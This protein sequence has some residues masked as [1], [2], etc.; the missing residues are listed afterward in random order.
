MHSTKKQRQSKVDDFFVVDIEAKLRRRIPHEPV[1]SKRQHQSK[2]DDFFARKRS[3]N[4]EPLAHL[5][6]YST[7][8]E[9]RLKQIKLDKEGE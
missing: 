2:L 3:R 8:I 6:S 9:N 1:A 4:D 5:T 7:A